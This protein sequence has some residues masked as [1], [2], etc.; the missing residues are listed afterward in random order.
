[1]RAIKVSLG[2]N[3]LAEDAPRRRR[4]I[5]FRRIG[6]EVQSEDATGVETS[7]VGL[8]LGSDGNRLIVIDAGNMA[9]VLQVVGLQ[10]VSI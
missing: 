2:V 9:D 3:D 7:G 6:V 4:G 10:S 8:S 1:M 5:C